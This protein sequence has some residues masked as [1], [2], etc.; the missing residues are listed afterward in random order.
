MV[1]DYI[2]QRFGRRQGSRGIAMSAAPA[3]GSGAALPGAGRRVAGL[4]RKRLG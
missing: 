3:N 4:A 2:E 1:A